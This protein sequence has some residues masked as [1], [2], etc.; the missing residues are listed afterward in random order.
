MSLSSALMCL[1]FFAAPPSLD[2]LLMQ[3]NRLEAQAASRAGAAGG[4]VDLLR[5]REL[6]DWLPDGHLDAVFARRAA[7]AKAA[8]LV[9]AV[10]QFLQRDRA[11]MHMDPARAQAAAK[12]LG[13]IDAV[14]LRPGPAPHSTA[15]FTPSGWQAYPRGMGAGTLR[16]EAI[17]RP[18]QATRATVA[19]RLVSAEGGPAVLRLG[20]DDA[21]VVW[22]NGDEMYQSPAT[23][24]H[25]LDQAAIPIV[26]RPGDNRLVVSVQQK[27]GAWR[28]TMRVTDARGEP[29]EVQAHAD[30]WGEVPEP[31]EGDPPEDVESLWA[32]LY[33]AADAE[34]PVAQDLRD[35]ADYARI[36][37]LPD[38][39]QSIPRVAVEGTWRDDRS[40]RS[41]RAWLRILP[42]DERA[43][44]RSKHPYVRPIEQADVYAALRLRLGVAW[45]HYYARRHRETRA[46]V[47]GIIADAPMFQPAQRLRAVL[48]EDLGLTHR[49]VARLERLRARWPDRI[50]ALR[51]LVTSLQSASRIEEAV[52]QLEALQARA[53]RRPDDAFQLATVYAARGR[54]NRALALLDG[55][56]AARPDLTGYAIEAAEIALADGRTE[57]ALARFETLARAI[58]GDAT[59]ARRL[60]GLYL[61]TGD[62]ARAV[63]A[64]KGAD[65]NDPDVQASLARLTRRDAG[66]DL[67]PS[68]DVLRK[69]PPVAGAPAHVLYHHARTVVD[70]RGLAVRHV[71]RVVRVQSDEGGRRFAQWQLPYVPSTQRLE[72]MTA[73]LYRDGAPPASPRR[74][75]R[76]LSE[77]EY[78]LYYDLRAEVLD[79]PPPRDGDLIEVVWRLTD[80]DPDPAFPGYYGELAYLQEVAPRALSVVEIE[81]PEALRIEVVPRGVSVR[82][83]GSRIVARDV[84]GLPLE[85]GM[86]GPSS[87]RAYVHVSTAQSWTE[88][89]DRYRALLKDRDAPTAALKALALKWGGEGDARTIMGRLYAAVAAR[90][91]YVGLEFGV[92]SFL[93]AQPA[94]TLARGY[95]DCKDKATLLIALARARGIDAHL[96][97]VRTRPSGAIAA[98]PASF[99]VFDHA[100]VYLPGLDRFM[101]PTVDRNDPW[102]LPPNDQGAKAFVIDIDSDLRE[103]PM[104]PAESNRSDWGI[105][106]E[107]RPDGSA[108][109]RVTWTTRGQPASLARR[110]LEAEGAR[111]EFVER[112]LTERFPGAAIMPERYAGLAPAFDPVIVSGL[113]QLPAFRASGADAGF[114]VPLGGATWGLVARFAQAASRKSPLSLSYHR[115]QSMRLQLELPEGFAART[116]APVSL[117][118]PFGVLR[119]EA[120]ATGR[121]LILDVTF[122]LTTKRVDPEDYRAF[123]AWLAQVDQ[124][125]ARVVEVRR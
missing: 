99:A 105:T 95:G 90:T 78:R 81:G 80:T 56:Y 100:I 124:A 63:A 9:R 41:L 115:R 106:A 103:I 83:Q 79:F 8:P 55:V 120:R 109:G 18:N 67:G 96:V 73:R 23:H 38:S 51:A 89:N 15:R 7:D 82:R 75:D 71:R 68:L 2:P 108:R 12:A 39:D 16:L 122:D 48:D 64:L 47:E 62:H 35:L 97:L 93:P 66:V 84:P 25:F 114:D 52:T 36:A 44:V 86:P 112:L 30:V 69:T 26:L 37:G 98:Q 3:A 50:G 31:A 4:A 20:Y 11:L 54:T 32:T 116:P 77:P 24:P 43:D 91:R 74:S 87:M 102:T 19:T 111:A 17:L 123:R 94:V 101:D 27:S 22:L 57:D 65:A 119:A 58:Q 13:L 34:P 72:L 53:E 49:A 21:V 121:R 85:V 29:L 6:A 45:Q 104:A 40:P 46:L 70:A 10:A 76:D 117:R 113:V 125:L 118:S 61:A 107:V 88:I 28:L 42:E 59:V 14:Q 5:M 33:A 60:A 92:R 1:A 110:A